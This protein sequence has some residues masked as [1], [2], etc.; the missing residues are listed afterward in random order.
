M[1]GDLHLMGKVC[2]FI[3]RL[4]QRG[5]KA[6]IEERVDDGRVDVSLIKDSIKI[7]CEIAVS[8]SVEYEIKN[9]KKCLNAKYSFVYVIS[10]NEKHLEKIKK[11]AKF[12]IEEKEN[13]RIHFSTPNNINIL[14]DEFTVKEKME[15][16]RI[17]GYRA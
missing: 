14:L 15:D 17:K 1:D 16:K 11:E 4:V 8:N 5:F 9:I 12:E 3:L 10:K 6:S 13:T 7:A 2:H